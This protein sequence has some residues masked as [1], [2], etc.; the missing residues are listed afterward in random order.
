MTYN[1]RCNICL[2]HPLFSFS[3]ISSQIHRYNLNRLPNN[4]IHMDDQEI[5]QYL[6]EKK[7]KE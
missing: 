2:N 7:K 6:H 1:R 5:Y 4:Y 3:H